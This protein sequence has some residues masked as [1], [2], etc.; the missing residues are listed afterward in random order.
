MPRGI[1]LDG[2]SR[3]MWLKSE[4]SRLTQQLDNGEICNEIHYLEIRLR[5]CGV[6]E[7]SALL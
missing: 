7:F 1:V 3:T 2:Q 4:E 6:A 5:G